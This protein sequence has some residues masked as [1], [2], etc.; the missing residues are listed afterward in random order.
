M[1]RNTALPSRQRQPQPAPFT[2]LSAVQQQPPLSAVQ[3]QPHHAPS[4]S[5]LAEAPPDEEQAML[6]TVLRERIERAETREQETAT[7]LARAQATIDKLLGVMAQ[8][9]QGA[10]GGA[11]ELRAARTGLGD[12]ARHHGGYGQSRELQRVFTTV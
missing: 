10:R 3:Q 9:Q 7:A 4:H 2:P 12:W 5:L 1:Q 8:Q 6:V 11:A